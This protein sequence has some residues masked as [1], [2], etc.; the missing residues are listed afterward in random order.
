MMENKN[1]PQ[2]FGR[3]KAAE[4]VKNGGSDPDLITCPSCDGR[5]GGNAF[6]CGPNTGGLCWMPCSFCHGSGKVWSYNGTQYRV[7]RELSEERREKNYT[8]REIAALYGCGMAD[9][10][11]L[12]HGRRSLVE[13]DDARRWLSQQPAHERSKVPPRDYYREELEKRGMRTIGDAKGD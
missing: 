13:I 9:W 5:K 11:N 10:S 8:V 12:E 1:E 3:T 7:G 4:L 6:V 2:D